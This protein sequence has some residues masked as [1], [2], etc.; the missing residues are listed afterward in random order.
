VFSVVD[1]NLNTEFTEESHPPDH[2]A[3]RFTEFLIPTG[4]LFVLLLC[5]CALCATFV[6]SVVKKKLK[7]SGSVV[8]KNLNTEITEESHPPDHRAGRFTVFLISTRWLQVFNLPPNAVGALINF[9][10][11]S[12]FRLRTSVFFNI[13]SLFF[14]ISSV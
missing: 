2:R 7:H 5:L 6:C 14:I 1:K 13:S 9:L 3:G 12:V 11:P 10:P 4:W 8:D